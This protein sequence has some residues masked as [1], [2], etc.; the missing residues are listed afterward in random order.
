[1]YLPAT[2]AVADDTDV[3]PP[4]LP[5]GHGNET[6]LVVEDN[7]AV[8][9]FVVQALRDA[10]YQV[11]DSGSPLHM[12]RTLAA[13]DTAYDLLLT[14]VVLP[15][16]DGY[17]LARRAAATRPSLKILYM[18]GYADN[19]SLREEALRTGIDLL[20]KPFSSAILTAKVR[21]VLDRTV[22]L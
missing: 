9:G 3:A 6:V 15:G 4:T 19:P 10:G 8:R 17:E 2:R 21:D 22:A 13:D 14:D 11:T 16:I 7:D 1:V 18:S 20:E 12:L 5:A